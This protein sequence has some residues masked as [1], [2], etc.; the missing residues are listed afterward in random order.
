MGRRREGRGAVSASSSKS[1]GVSYEEAVQ[2]HDE[3]RIR[4]CP[5]CERLTV[6]RPAVVRSVSCFDGHESADEETVAVFHGAA[7]KAVW[8]L[9]LARQLATD[10][11]YQGERLAEGAESITTAIA[12]DIDA[13]LTTLT[14]QEVPK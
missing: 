10:E 6:D 14:Q 4:R 5:T 1:E 12:S 13:A 8:T 11:E 7:A 2:T 9:F 3:V